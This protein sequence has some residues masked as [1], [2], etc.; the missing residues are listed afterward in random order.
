MQA[1]LF[2]LQARGIDSRCGMPLKRIFRSG[3]H[4]TRLDHLGRNASSAAMN[5]LMRAGFT[6]TRTL[7]PPFQLS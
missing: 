2:L 3:W 5:K 6:K 4:R 1:T 7:R